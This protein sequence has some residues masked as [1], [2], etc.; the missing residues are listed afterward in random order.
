M[1]KTARIQIAAAFA[2]L[3]LVTGM[4]WQVSSAA[5]TG[6][7]TNDEAWSAGTVT[8][9]DNYDGTA[10]FASGNTDIKPGYAAEQCIAVAYDG[11]LVSPNIDSVKFH[12]S[13][14]GTS[15]DGTG[16]G[17]DLS[18]HMYVEVVRGDPG[19]SCSNLLSLTDLTGK[20]TVYANGLMS[21]LPA[22]GSPADTQWTPSAQGETVPFLFNVELPSS[23]GNGAQ[24]D[25]VGVT[26]T[27][28][29]TSN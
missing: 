8:L 4:V 24:G 27:W 6:S 26:F 28:N 3:L 21:G 2:A 9:S 13:I 29:V 22:D 7:T 14:A 5:F 23:T 1:T 11:S 12:A 25:T 18:D 16:D 20:T 19:E 15:A 10:M 17:T